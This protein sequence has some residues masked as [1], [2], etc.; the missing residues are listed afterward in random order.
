MPVT[1]FLRAT[2]LAAGLGVGMGS[3]AGAGADAAPLVPLAR[4][5][6]WAGVSGLIGYGDR[7]WFVNSVKH[8]DHNSADIYS[9]DPHSGAVRYERHLFSQDAGRPTVHHG[10]L[11]WPFEDARFSVGRGEFMVTDGHAWQ[12]REFTARRR[13][14]HL[15]ALLS[16]DGALYAGSGGFTA[17]LNRSDDAGVTWRQVTEHR[18]APNSFS[19]ILSLTT[20]GNV[21]Y[22][23][24]FASSERGVKLQRLEN[25]TLGAV[26]DWPAG[27]SADAL[28][29]YDGRVYALHQDATEVSVWRTDGNASEP[30]PALANARVRALAAGADALWAIAASNRGGVLWRSSDGR[31]WRVAQRFDRDE[32][33]DVTVYAGQVYVGMLGADGRGVLFGP[34]APAPTARSQAPRAMPEA[35]PAPEPDLSQLLA[36]LDRALAEYAGFVAS[37]GRLTALLAPIAA[38]H[39]DAAAEALAQRIGVVPR[40]AGQARF[41]GRRVTAGEQADWQI[42]WALARNGRGRVPSELLG[43][44][45]R[46]VARRSEK[47]ADPAPAAAWAVAELGQRDDAT[48][49]VL[50]ERLDRAGDPPWLA[51]DLVGALTAVTG[52]RFAY[53]ATAWRSWRAAGAI[54]C[55]P[56]TQESSVAR[57][58]AELA[59]IPGGVFVMGDATGEPDETPRKIAVGSFKLMRHEVTNREFATFVAATNHVTDPERSGV[60]YVWT[61]RW[62]A[63]QGADWRHPQGAGSAIDGLA[64]HPVVQVSVR[65]ATAYCAWRGLSLPTEAQWEYAARGNDGR[66]YPWGDEAPAQRG[67]RRANFGTQRCCAPDESDGFI[68]TAPVGS[69]PLGASPFGVQDMAGNVW[70][71]TTGA[72]APGSDDVALRG[73]GW[74]N[75]PYC[76]RASYRH[77]NPPDIGLEMVGFRCAGN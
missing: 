73:G 42:R 50:I 25:G 10:L 75:E 26:P 17:T 64:T 9:Y 37:G 66:R 1:S 15:H 4:V 14:L 57:R 59:T 62:R 46:S 16:H 44:P 29:R 28:T 51:G 70:E 6:P 30:V 24:L 68:R 61:D 52:C 39:S 31:E 22:A 58:L 47:Y 13:I 8:V 21:V 35:S 20:L 33:V 53:D 5:G 45:W 18:N 38:S 54:P 12:W 49:A 65:D 63:V 34:P 11:Y 77:G 74:G 55:G 67:A 2:V 43:A 71:W 27:E 48:L 72:Y 7:L 36:E 60:G 40:G 41:A 23:G 69:F 3:A 19:R 56:V 76:L 32:P